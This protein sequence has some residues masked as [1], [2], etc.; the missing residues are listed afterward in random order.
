MHLLNSPEYGRV[1]ICQGSHGQQLGEDQPTDD[2]VVTAN[3]KY[4]DSILFLSL[5]LLFKTFLELIIFL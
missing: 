4:L 5:K 3:I 1:E 2:H